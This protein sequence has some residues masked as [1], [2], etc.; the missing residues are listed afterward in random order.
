M[1]KIWDICCSYRIHCHRN[2]GNL[3]SRSFAQLYFLVVDFTGSHEFL[4]PS[5][6]QPLQRAES[7]GSSDPDSEWVG[8]FPSVAGQSFMSFTCRYT[9][10]SEIC[11]S[12]C[13][14]LSLFAVFTGSVQNNLSC[15]LNCIL[16][17]ILFLWLERNPERFPMGDIHKW[18]LPVCKDYIHR[19]S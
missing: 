11:V 9:C 13:I 18:L 7:D 12:K 1:F 2:I 4:I 19:E 8:T 15:T 16:L 6:V 3:I 10:M 5:K 14:R 17:V